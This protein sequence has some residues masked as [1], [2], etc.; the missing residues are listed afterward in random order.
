MA[1]ATQQIQVTNLDESIVSHQFIF[2]QSDYDKLIVPVD[3]SLSL[4]DSLITNNNSNN[5][6][7]LLKSDKDDETMDVS[8]VSD[9]F[10]ITQSD[11][12][13]LIEPL[14]LSLPINDSFIFNT[15]KY[16]S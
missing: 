7:G 4:Y 5:N 16:F 1:T 2:T 11:Y 6:S 9:Q 15:E 13:R 8:I 14:D 10:M 12:D 3:F